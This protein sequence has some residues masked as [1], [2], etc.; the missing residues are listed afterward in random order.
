MS[1]T[2]VCAFLEVASP[3]SPSLTFSSPSRKTLGGVRSL[4]K[5]I[6]ERGIRPEKEK[7]KGGAGGGGVSFSACLS[8]LT[9]DHISLSRRSKGSGVERGTLREREREE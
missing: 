9:I 1:T 8:H 6:A 7:G 4:E 5:V 3:K 2:L